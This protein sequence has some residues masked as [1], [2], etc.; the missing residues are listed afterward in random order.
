[1][2][3]RHVRLAGPCLLVSPG[4]TS[5]VLP[6]M[7]DNAAPVLSDI[8]RKIQLLFSAVMT[9]SMVIQLMDIFVKLG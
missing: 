2:A 7:E 5:G 9:L 8:H 3:C 6:Q 4:T 1:M